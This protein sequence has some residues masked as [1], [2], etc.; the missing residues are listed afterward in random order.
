MRSPRPELT[1]RE[2]SALGRL[3]GA[4]TTGKSLH[5]APADPSRAT[6]D[7]L[8]KRGGWVELDTDGGYRITNYGMN[9]F[10]TGKVVRG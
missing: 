10:Y 4:Y 1:T 5:L 7:A 6:F 9:A 8:M 3:V 2:R